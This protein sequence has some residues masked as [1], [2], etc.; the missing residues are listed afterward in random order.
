M[1][2]GASSLTGRYWLGSLWY[3]TDP[4]DAPDDDKSAAA[5]ETNSGVCDVKWVTN[6]TVI[7][8]LDSGKSKISFS[9]SLFT[10]ALN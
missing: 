6:K 3:F 5:V 1:I 8:G 10:F 2:L 9:F 7:A 4:E